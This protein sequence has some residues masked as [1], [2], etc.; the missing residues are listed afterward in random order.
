MER[1][2]KRFL[3]QVD[4][5]D[6]GASYLTI[7]IPD[8]EKAAKEAAILGTDKS[9]ILEGFEAGDP[10]QWYSGRLVNGEETTDL[11]VLESWLEADFVPFEPED[12]SSSS[13]DESLE[14]IIV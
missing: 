6:I 3:K 7:P 5:N 11:P 2:R 4:C 9:I 8:P 14:S 10:E 1:V 12:S 13:S